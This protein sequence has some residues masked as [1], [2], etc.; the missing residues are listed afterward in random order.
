MVVNA[1]QTI[2]TLQ[3]ALETAQVGA[4]TLKTVDHDTKVT[5]FQR[6][7]S[8]LQSVLDA[9]KEAVSQANQTIMSLRSDLETAQVGAEIL[10]VGYDTKIVRF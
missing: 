8:E 5:C 9:Q 2:S 3:S 1:N 7:K 10:V 4:E 6:D